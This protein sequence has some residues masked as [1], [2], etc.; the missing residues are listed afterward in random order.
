MTNIP[1][2]LAVITTV[3]R[4]DTDKKARQGVTQDEK[5][6]SEDKRLKVGIGK[7][8]LQGALTNGSEEKA[9]QR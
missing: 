2:A 5:N 7:L 1:T 6:D 9:N 4:A 8:D 3:V